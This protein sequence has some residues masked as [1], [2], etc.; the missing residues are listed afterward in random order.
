MPVMG[1]GKGGLKKDGRCKPG[2]KGGRME[3]SV[4]ALW[5]S[6]EWCSRQWSVRCKG[7]VTGVVNKGESLW[8]GGQGDDDHRVCDHGAL[9][10]SQTWVCIPSEMGVAAWLWAGE[11]HDVS[12]VL[13]FRGSLRGWAELHWRGPGWKEHNQ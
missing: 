9:Q 3:V 13:C 7:P 5:L 11:K 10:A 6:G 12:C 8:R 4:C 2:R 1:W